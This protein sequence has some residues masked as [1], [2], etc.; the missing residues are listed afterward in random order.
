LWWFK[1]SLVVLNWIRMFWY[2]Y[3]KCC[4]KLSQI[5]N[6]KKPNKNKKKVFYCKLLSMIIFHD[7][8]EKVRFLEKSSSSLLLTFKNSVFLKKHLFLKI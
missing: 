7:Y 3:H 2:S 4:H 5:L 1:M 6:E 8:I